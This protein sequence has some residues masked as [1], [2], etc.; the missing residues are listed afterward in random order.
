MVSNRYRILTFLYD[1]ENSD[2]RY[3]FND[4]QDVVLFY[5]SED[6]RADF[7]AY[8]KEHQELVDSQLETIDQYNHIIAGNE[9]KTA[10]YK[11]RLRVGVALNDLL[12]QF[13]EK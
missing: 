7:E 3:A 1:R 5:H 11:E 12:K 13:R 9:T 4:L 2:E 10:V 8:I 6:E